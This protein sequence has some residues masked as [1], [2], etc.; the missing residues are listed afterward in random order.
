MGSEMFLGSFKMFLGGSA[1]HG[2][3]GGPELREEQGAAMCRQFSPH[4]ENISNH[5]SAEV[6]PQ[7]IHGSILH[8]DSSKTSI[9]LICSTIRAAEPKQPF[10]DKMMSPSRILKSSRALLL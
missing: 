10:T 2:S 6:H 4:S 8:K 7:K 1:P 9:V 3:R 5:A